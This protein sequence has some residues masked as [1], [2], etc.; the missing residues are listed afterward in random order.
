[1]NVRICPTP[2]ADNA[3]VAVDS[4]RINTRRETERLIAALR[5]AADT[6]WPKLPVP[7]KKP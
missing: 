1:M 5:K 7:E 3:C 4:I 2:V 6:V